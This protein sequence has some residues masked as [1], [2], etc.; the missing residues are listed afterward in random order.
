[1]QK[2]IPFLLVLISVNALTAQF[3][4]DEKNVNNYEGFFNFHFQ[5]SSGKVWLV[6]D[7]LDHEFLYV[8]A[9]SQGLGSNDIGLDR[10]QLGNGVVVK[11][12]RS[13]TKLMLVQ[14]NQSYRAVTENEKEIIV[15]S[16]A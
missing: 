5:E 1:M 6:V 11:F 14:P 7:E 8:N 9:L 13:G 4:A 15:R 2:L 3:L 12:I 10:G 16:V